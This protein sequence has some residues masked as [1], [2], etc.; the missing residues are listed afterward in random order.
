VEL[1]VKPPLQLHPVL[2]VRLVPGPLVVV[3]A[4]H[5]SMPVS[6]HCPLEQGTLLPLP[7]GTQSPV[8]ISHTWLVEEQVTFWQRL[9]LAK[10]H[11]PLAGLQMSP[12]EQV[13]FVQRFVPL[14]LPLPPPPLLPLLVSNMLQLKKELV[15]RN[16]RISVFV[17][18]I[19][20]TPL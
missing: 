6:D 19:L 16:E 1:N 15:S 8:V 11:A 9:V 2:L 17:F 12:L 10:I 20:R 7:V 14:Q 5:G 18:F 3:Q 13:T 4:E